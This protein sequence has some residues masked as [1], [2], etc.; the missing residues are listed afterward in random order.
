MIADRGDNDGYGAFSGKVVSG[1]PSENA[2]S[3]KAAFSGK[4]VFGF[5]SEYATNAIPACS[6]ADR[7][8][9]ARGLRPQR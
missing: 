1:F 8:D 4:A 7:R 3:D 6:G 2:T 9:A 5:P